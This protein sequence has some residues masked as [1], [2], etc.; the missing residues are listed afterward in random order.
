MTIDLIFIFTDFIRLFKSKLNK[1]NIKTDVK[2]Q[3]HT[4]FKSYHLMRKSIVFKIKIK[5]LVTV[6]IINSSMPPYIYFV[7]NYFNEIFFFVFSVLRQKKVSQI[8]FI[9]LNLHFFFFFYLFFLTS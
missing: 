2:L 5:L 3:N 6:L 4:K 7:Y 1:I 8:Y 9:N